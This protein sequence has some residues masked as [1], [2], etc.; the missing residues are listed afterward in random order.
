MRTRSIIFTLIVNAAVAAQAVEA[1]RLQ[2]A[3][4]IFGQRCQTSQGMCVLGAPAPVGT[5]CFCPTP[6]GPAPGAVVQ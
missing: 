4:F 3:Q 5:R 1:P 6:F 2:L